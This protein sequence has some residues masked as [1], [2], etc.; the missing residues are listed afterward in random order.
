MWGEAEKDFAYVEAEEK[1]EWDHEGSGGRLETGI[2]GVETVGFHRPRKSRPRAMHGL[3]PEE[4]SIVPRL[5]R[6]GPRRLYP[7][8]V[9][10]DRECPGRRLQ[11]ID[12]RKESHRRG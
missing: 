2:I 9:G 1:P 10:L 11:L 12:G 6:S 4:Q 7:L 8:E 3:D 5:T